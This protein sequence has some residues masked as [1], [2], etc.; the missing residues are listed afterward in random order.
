[1]ALGNIE[2]DKPNAQEWAEIERLLKDFIPPERVSFRPLADPQEWEIETIERGGKQIETAKVIA[3]QFI[4]AEVVEDLLD[5]VVGLGSWSNRIVGAATS[6]GVLTAAAQELSIFGVTKA[7]V[8]DSLPTENEPNKRTASDA[9]KRAAKTWGVFRYAYSGPTIYAQVER[10]SK[11]KWRMVK[12]EEDR[13][14]LKL[15]QPRYVQWPGR[16]AV[17]TSA[18]QTPAP[19]QE[20]PGPDPALAPRPVARRP[21]ATAPADGFNGSFTARRPAPATESNGATGGM[22]TDKQ[23]KAIYAIARNQRAMSE[24]EVDALCLETYGTS[25][26]NLSKSEASRF[27]D[28]L[29]EQ[30]AA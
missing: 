17:P 30:P 29:K 2:G 11:G 13:L 8:G 5:L 25:P 24:N 14:R 9:L 4:D 10:G 27:I 3:A 18:D 7:N 20:Q 19:N 22:L 12:G 15:P 1:M 28:I 21:T 6:G 23:L 26:A 16:E